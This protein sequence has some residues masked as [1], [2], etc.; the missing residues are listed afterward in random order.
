MCVGQ[1]LTLTILTKFYIILPDD[2]GHGESSKPSDAMVCRRVETTCK[3]VL[4]FKISVFCAHSV[5]GIVGHHQLMHPG[6]Q[7]EG[8]NIDLVR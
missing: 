5:P 4:D 1:G 8:T 7:S 3:K 2:I 6:S